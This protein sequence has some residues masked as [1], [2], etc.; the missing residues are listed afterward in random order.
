MRLGPTA[1]LRL[2]C[3]RRP[4]FR[5]GRSRSIY[6][7][8]VG[9][10]A[11]RRPAALDRTPYL[12]HIYVSLWLPALLVVE[13]E[14]AVAAAAAK[15]SRF[16]ITVTVTGT[17][18]GKLSLRYGVPVSYSLFPVA[19]KPAAQL[20]EGKRGEG[21]N[22]STVQKVRKF[23][24]WVSGVWRTGGRTAGDTRTPNQDEETRPRFPFS[25]VCVIII[26]SYSTAPIYQKKFF[27]FRTPSPLTPL[28]I[29]VLLR[30]GSKVI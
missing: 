27:L 13:V 19:T 8:Y 29:C 30:R 18:K 9:A 3:I 20:G 12:P 10:P 15:D 24:L 23:F 26:I 4:G 22:Y 17:L 16:L 28:S 7:K 2:F 14:G 6:S 1:C 21:T 25:F 5:Y 11:G